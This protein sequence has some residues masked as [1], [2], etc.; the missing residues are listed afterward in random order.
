M[1]LL[2][3]LISLY[4][5][6]LLVTVVISWLNPTGASGTLGRIDY[7]C[8]LVT[9]PLLRPIRRV[10]PAVRVGGTGLDFSVFILMFALGIIE[11]AI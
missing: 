10:I 8:R 5:L 11:R 7:Y 4:I 9:E 2:K 1:N 3:D 6:V